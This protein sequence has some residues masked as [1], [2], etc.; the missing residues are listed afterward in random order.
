MRSAGI[1]AHEVERR[2]L[3]VARAA[4]L[5]DPANDFVRLR[6]KT[7]RCH[8]GVSRH[9]V[10]AGSAGWDLDIAWAS[11]ERAASVPLVAPVRN[12][13]IRIGMESALRQAA[14]RSGHHRY[15]AAASL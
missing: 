8:L 3:Q 4:W 6:P 14:A 5:D 15:G 2:V 13:S 11:M 1:A 10:V 9:R 12:R 7:S